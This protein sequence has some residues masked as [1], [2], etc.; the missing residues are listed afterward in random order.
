MGLAR[1]AI[2]PAPGR[3]RPMSRPG[4]RTRGLQGAGLHH[5]VW[6]CG[7]SLCVRR[8]GRLGWLSVRGASRRRG[9]AR[10]PS[11]PRCDGRRHRRC[12]YGR[13]RIGEQSVVR[14]RE[15][16]GR[17]PRVAPRLLPPDRFVPP[18]A[19]PGQMTAGIRN[20]AAFSRPWHSGVGL[21]GQAAPRLNRRSAPA[22]VVAA[23][24]APCGTGPGG[25]RW[26][27][28]ARATHR[29]F[30]RPGCVDRGPGPGPGIGCRGEGA[31]RVEGQVPG[32]GECATSPLREAAAVLGAWR[33]RWGR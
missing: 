31:H 23:R 20:W 32:R 2:P 19:P 9:Q 4:M 28:H 10:Q 27:R 30:A 3:Q 33:S 22:M 29:P 16:R 21:V 15:R 7:C 25:V 12:G 11:R 13:C 1:Y 26:P 8:V 5:T 17:G 6:G 24:P 18:A 14:R